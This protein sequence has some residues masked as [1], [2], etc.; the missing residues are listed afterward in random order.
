MSISQ[1]LSRRSLSPPLLV[2]L[3]V[4][5]IGTIAAWHYSA[6]HLALSHYDARAHLVVARRIFDSLMPGWQQIGAVW[7]PLPHV[8]NAVPV[9]ID[10]WYRSGAS[11]IAIS[12]LSTALGTWA[13]ARFIV[14]ET[15]S[16]AGA[17]AGGLLV[18]VNPNT[19]YLQSTPMTEPLL[20]AMTMVAVA[21]TA[22]W[23]DRRGAAP[24]A[25][26]WALVAACMTR[27][28]AW[29]ITVAILVLALAALVR[30]GERLSTAAIS[31][32]RLAAYPAI[33]IVLFILN[34]LIVANVLRTNLATLPE[35]MRDRR[36]A[37]ALVFLG[38]LALV[39]IQWWA[40]DVAIDWL[41][42]PRS[43]HSKKG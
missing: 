37:Q 13:L 2:A 40:Y 8:L 24:R 7:L 1:P 30:K 19:L 31:C 27:Y 11:A 4:G 32:A 23:V 18:I 26:G 12:V 34:S 36:W 9:Q 33:A 5:L 16:V 41:W 21:L 43:R 10:A 42:P 17:I 29:L 20:F 14:R 22:E 6:I 38:P 39:V 3:L 15:G 35:F 25:A 28:E